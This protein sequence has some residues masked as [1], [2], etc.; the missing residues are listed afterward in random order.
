MPRRGRHFAFIKQRPH[1]LRPQAVSGTVPTVPLAAAQIHHRRCIAIDFRH[2][3][4]ARQI[5]GPVAFG[6]MTGAAGHR[7]LAGQ[8]LVEKQTRAEFDRIRIAGNAVTGIN[9]C[10]RWPRPVRQNGFDFGIAEHRFGGIIACRARKRG[11]QHANNRRHRENIAECDVRLRL[12]VEIDDRFS[13]GP[14]AGP[15]FQQVCCNA[16]KNP[17]ARPHFRQG[18]KM[19]CCAWR[20]I[21]A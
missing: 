17:A 10:R 9:R 13:V 21:I 2:T 7:T 16:T 3:D 18:L 8:A 6:H 4:A 20:K 19:R 11:Q 14:T 5:I 1:R 15:V 12:S